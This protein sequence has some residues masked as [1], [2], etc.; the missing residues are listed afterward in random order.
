MVTGEGDEDGDEEKVEIDSPGSVGTL[1]GAG[2]PVPSRAD[3]DT[4]SL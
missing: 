3:S 4:S 2:V 1:L